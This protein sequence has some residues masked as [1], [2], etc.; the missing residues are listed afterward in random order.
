MTAPVAIEGQ[1]PFRF[2]VDTGANQSVV[3]EELAGRLGLRRGDPQP[4]HGVA[5]V[6]TTGVVT[7]VEL[8]IGRRVEKGL[9]LSVL[10]QAAIGG[11]GML[12]IDRLSGQRLTLDFQER[13]LQIEDSRRRAPDWDE[14][15]IRARQRNGQLTR[16]E[17][18]LAGTPVLAFLD[19]GAQSSIGNLALRALADGGS[20][21]RSWRACR[22]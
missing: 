22:F 6:R 16:V 13:R 21:A 7:G 9:T 5:G 14:V 19:S 1:G 17:A 8:R 12:G 4:L 10:P 3:S 2:V 18:D 20:L 11:V 15:A